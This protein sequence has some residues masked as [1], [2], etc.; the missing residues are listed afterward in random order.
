MFLRGINYDVGTTFTEGK[1]SRPD[2]NEAIIKNEI[3][4]IKNDLNCDAIKIT[5]HDVQ[6]LAK[7]A[8]FALQEGLQ[9]WL[10]PSYID[11]TKEEALPHLIDC[12]VAAE[13][14]RANG[15][16]IF[17]L[18][19][20]YSLFLKGF[21]KG[22]TIYKRLGNMF[23]PRGLILSLLGLRRGM[24]NKL[25]SFLSDA[26]ERVR[27]NFGGKLTYA[28]GEWEKI[29]WDIF[30]FI[31]VDHYRGSYNKTVYVKQLQAYFKFN[32]PV[33]ILDFVFFSYKGAAEKGGMGWAITEEVNGQRVIKG[34]PVRDETVQANYI[35]DLL[36][37]FKQE[38]VHAAFIF[39]F[40]NPMYKHNSDPR[41][42]LDMASYGIVKPINEPAYKGLPWI[43]KEA[44]YRLSA[45]YG[46]MKKA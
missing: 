17:V 21:L 35:T 4:I 20:E 3:G 31:G 18:G 38:K 1:L 6:R 5:G 28:S 10:T 43:P 24:Y 19:F 13:K 16:I 2:F 27:E 7:A 36:G 15:E 9:V 8:E 26:A 29:N 46:A 23:S 33:A 22:D 37:I 14:L 45:Y 41:F 42:D 12:A 11:A 32:K 39:T 34:E 30:D 40:I 25:N 44:F